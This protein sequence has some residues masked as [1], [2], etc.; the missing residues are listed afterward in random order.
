MSPKD[1]RGPQ[2]DEAI[3]LEVKKGLE[4]AKSKSV[5]VRPPPLRDSDEDIVTIA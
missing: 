4:V 3:I 1:T 2:K 5:A